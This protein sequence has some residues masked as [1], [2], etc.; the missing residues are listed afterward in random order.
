MSEQDDILYER[1]G[2]VAFVTLNRPKALNALTMAMCQD[3]DARLAAWEADPEVRA[4][5]VKGAGDRAFCAGGDVRAIWQSARDGTSHRAEFFAAEYR[6]NRRIY[7]FPKPYI[8]LLD[9]ITMGG[10]VGVSVH[11]SHR[12]VTENTLFAMPETG[13]GLFPDVGAS[14]VLPRLPGA[15]GM[16]LGLTGARLKAADCLYTGLATHYLER[17]ALDD[18]QRALVSLEW[19]EIGEAVAERV[20]GLFRSNAG[21]APLI[22]HRE[23][24]D[25]VFSADSV[26]AILAALRREPGDWA[27]ETLTG[28]ESRSPTS[29]KVTYRAIR[30]GAKLE[31]DEVMTM[32]YRLSQACTAAHDFSEGIRA[33]IIEKDNK[34]A[35]EPASLAAVSDDAVAACFAPLGKRD[36]AFS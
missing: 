34:P 3:L 26:E 8:A 31:F 27:R 35:W 25:R 30:E 7:H 18:L 15:L 20:L 21:L 16:Y 33:V 22:E 28:L 1:Q 5:V 19:S 9:G 12:V 10:G 4:V 24:I 2:A 36:L 14:H 32:E 23:T 13:I 6:L 11:G 17:E 29:L